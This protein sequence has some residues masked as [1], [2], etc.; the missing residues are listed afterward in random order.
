MNFE[1]N[2]VLNLTRGFAMFLNVILNSKANLFCS[3]KNIYRELEQ[4]I[5]TADAVEDLR[6]FRAN[7]GPGMSMNWP[8]FEVRSEYLKPSF[9]LSIFSS[10][11]FVIFLS[12]VTLKFG[13]LAVIFF[14]CF[15]K[16]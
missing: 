14:V 7:Q 9:V 8:Q 13:L 11:L 6:W 15:Y 12:G 2:F 3:Y 5:K 16:S 1:K 10:L 4:N